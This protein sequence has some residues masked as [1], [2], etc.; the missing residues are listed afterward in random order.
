MSRFEIWWEA[1]WGAAL[2][3]VFVLGVAVA[4][5]A[6]LFGRSPNAVAIEEWSPR[7]GVF[8]V[9][10]TSS[11]VGNHLATISCVPIPIEEK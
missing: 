3:L 4:A 9:M 2:V 10:A 7:P 8:C 1:W 11:V 5:E 6:G